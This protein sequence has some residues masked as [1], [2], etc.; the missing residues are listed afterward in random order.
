MGLL[1]LPRRLLGTTLSTD[2][3]S[4]STGHVERKTLRAGIAAMRMSRQMGFGRDKAQRWALK[5]LE[6]RE[7]RALL[8][9]EEV[10]NVGAGLVA[11]DGA[12]LGP[13]GNSTT[14]PDSGM[15]RPR[16]Y[17]NAGEAARQHRESREYVLV[18]G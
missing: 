6:R 16:V 3:L 2:R 9:D 14:A 12:A 13:I 7:A 5:G 11:K 10:R 1:A 15:A 17:G 8:M 4:F 18:W